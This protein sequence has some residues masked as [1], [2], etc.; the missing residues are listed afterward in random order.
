MIESLKF[1]HIGIAV[2]NIEVTTAFYK[3]I[4]YSVSDIVFDNNQNVNVC[5]LTKQGQPAI[6][7]VEPVDDQSP[8]VKILTKTGVSPY[9]IC[10]EVDSISEETKN[11][12]AQKFV[13]VSKAKMSPLF[14]ANVAFLFHKNVGLIE[15][16]E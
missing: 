4:G 1:H 3:L 15:L 14:H 12:K 16:I 6:E 13:L 11:L 9:H 8:V 2:N 5:Y 10:Y 7:L